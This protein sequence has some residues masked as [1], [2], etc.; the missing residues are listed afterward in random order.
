[1]TELIRFI[2]MVLGLVAACLLIMALTE[3]GWAWPIP[4]VAGLAFAVVM[5]YAGAF[6][7]D[8]L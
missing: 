6:E 4:V 5:W 1:M 2:L 7:E 3:A 8:E